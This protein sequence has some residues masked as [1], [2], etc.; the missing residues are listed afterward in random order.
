MQ[1]V[2]FSTTPLGRG[3]PVEI[4]HLVGAGHGAEAAAD[5]ALVIDQHNALFI[6]VGGLHRANFDA[7]WVVAMLARPGDKGHRHVGIFALNK[8][9]DLIPQDGSVSG[10]L[11]RP[12]DRGIIL[13]A[14]SGRA[15]LAGKTFI[16]IDYHS[17]TGHTPSP[18]AL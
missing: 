15:A 10:G 6:D 9:E 14:T 8:R 4:T 2:H 12:G 1:K 5:T 13:H 18:Y 11:I 17:P 3:V 7:G 16:K